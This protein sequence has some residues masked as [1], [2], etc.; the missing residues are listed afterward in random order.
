MTAPR[1]GIVGGGQLA[2]LLAEEVNEQGATLYCLDPDPQ[3]PAV[4]MGARHVPGHRLSAEDIK[5]LAGL[6]DV[7]TVDLEDVNVEALANLSESGMPVVPDPKTLSLMT[8][9]LRQK[10]VFREAGLPTSPF[11]A[12]DGSDPNLLGSQGWPAVQKAAEG[13]YDGRCVV[14]ISGPED[15][16]KR[17]RVPGFVEAFVP[18]ATELSVMVARDALGQVATWPTTEMEFD[19]RGNL[20][21]CLIAPARIPDDTA[22]SAQEL[23]TRA[24]TAFNGVG[25]FGVE[26][27][28]QPDGRLLINEIAPRTHNSGHYT[29]DAC[30][31]SQFRQ[32]F[33][34]LAGQPLAHTTQSAPAVM[35][36]V[37]GESGYE[38]K[39]VIEGLDEL[40]Q[41]PGVYPCLYGKKSCLPLRKMGHVTV[42]ADTLEVAQQLADTAREQIV[43]RGDKRI[44]S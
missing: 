15:R 27:F 5:K 25:V 28:L 7:I 20:L 23:A 10:E 17:L 33:N 44:Q 11:T 41:T 39:T 2:G 6:V 12:Y 19:E 16:D 29:I 40:L 13:G 3:C 30:A 32:Q 31:T 26:L 8:N 14:I 38:G 1:I 21:A 9:K 43:V 4:L 34:I 37:L 18:D 42:I 36:N 22:G 24:I 35:F